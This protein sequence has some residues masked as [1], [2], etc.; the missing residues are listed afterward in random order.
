M[1]NPPFIFP[2]IVSERAYVPQLFWCCPAVSGVPHYF[3]EVPFPSEGSVL[4]NEAILTELQGMLGTSTAV[5]LL[6]C[7]LPIGVIFVV[8]SIQQDQA[9][10]GMCG[11]PLNNAASSLLGSSVYG[12]VIVVPTASGSTVSNHYLRMRP[13]LLAVSPGPLSSDGLSHANVLDD[14]EANRDLEVVT[15]MLFTRQIEEAAAALDDC[16]E[17][18]ISTDIQR[19]LSALRGDVAPS[20][21]ATVGALSVDELLAPDPPISDSLKSHLHAVGVNLRYMGLVGRACESEEA[22]RCLLLEACART[23][24]HTVGQQLHAVQLQD[25]ANDE[26]RKNTFVSA[27]VTAIGLNPGY[28]SVDLRVLMWAKFPGS[29]VQNGDENEGDLDWLWSHGL[30][31]D[32]QA[33]VLLRTCELLGVQLSLSSALVSRGGLGPVGITVGDIV[34]FHPVVKTPSVTYINEL[35]PDAKSVRSSNNASMI[36]GVA[37]VSVEDGV[38]VSLQQPATLDDPFMFQHAIAALQDELTVRENV[39]T[40]DDDRVIRCVRDLGTLY[41]MRPTTSILA[42]PLLHRVLQARPT[43]ASVAMD[44]AELAIA[45]GDLVTANSFITL[46]EA[47]CAPVDGMKGLSRRSF[48]QP[49][50]DS[51]TVV[52][53]MAKVAHLHSKCGN[54]QRAEAIL[55]ACLTAAQGFVGAHNPEYAVLLFQLGSLYQRSGQ[56]QQAIQFLQQCCDVYGAIA[57]ETLPTPST[58]PRMSTAMSISSRRSMLASPTAAN[59]TRDS[60]HRQVTHG[61]ALL[62]LGSAYLSCGDS[63]RA[64]SALEEALTVQAGSGG[65]YTHVYVLALRTLATV[66]LGKG[67]YKQA[68]ALLK[69]CCALAP[70]VFGPSHPDSGAALQ[71]H[72]EVLLRLGFVDKAATTLQACAHIQRA[73]GDPDYLQTLQQLSGLY[74]TS[75]KPGKAIDTLLLEREVLARRGLSGTHLR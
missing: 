26:I 61:S 33:W 38:S 58:S 15:N 25:T 2:P 12:P 5:D 74:V 56:V 23:L 37:E 24:S 35:D 4:L 72:A 43:D 65:K 50:L 6:S 18:D 54:S 29:V 64:A 45:E 42:K 53:A 62:S 47:N 70:V 27:L 40:P 28:P 14:T 68:D 75:R 11:H 32:E 9:E 10:T 49:T 22:K 21:A 48:Q 41:L 20:D 46:C 13:E 16:F 30:D 57:K 60:F 55:T 51:M 31:T 34:G 8:G 3:M 17:L 67:E 69:E 59:T 63:D 19:K 44:L 7:P 52:R 36:S 71:C 39:L 1:I 66:R 73:C